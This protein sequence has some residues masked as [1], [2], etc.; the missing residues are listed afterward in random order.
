[1]T[2]MGSLGSDTGLIL[3]AALMSFCTMGQVCQPVCVRNPVL[4]CMI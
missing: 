2:V 3:V 1:V 4:K